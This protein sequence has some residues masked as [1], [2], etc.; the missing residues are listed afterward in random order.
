[1]KIRITIATR[2][3]CHPSRP[4]PIELA[5]SLCGMSDEQRDKLAVAAGQITGLWSADGSSVV[6]MYDLESRGPWWNAR[7]CWRD[8]A[9]EH[10]ATHV[11]VV[12][13]DALPAP[14]VA[15]T[16]S[17]AVRAVPDQILS[18]Y[19]SQPQFTD[20]LG[21]ATR[22]GHPWIATAT[23]CCGLATLMPVAIAR[24]FVRWCDAN[25]REDWKADDTRI[26]LYAASDLRRIWVSVPNLFQ[27]PPDGHGVDGGANKSSL[28]FESDRRPSAQW[29]SKPAFVLE[30]EA[31]AHRAM[32]LYVKARQSKFNGG[33]YAKSE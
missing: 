6:L 17:A 23:G 13:D 30:D 28:V 10:G 19:S 33:S 1:M 18:F 4:S 15:L 32:R 20:G 29:W 16:I 25:V 3:M 9:E 14:E 31:E 26:A 5:R 21:V 11:L 24:H 7:R 22:S 27:H 2:V 8:G 12:H